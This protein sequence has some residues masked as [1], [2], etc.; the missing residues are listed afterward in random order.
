MDNE[1]SKLVA[2]IVVW[3]REL[4]I[5]ETKHFAAYNAYNKYLKEHN[6]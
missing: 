4:A 1:E 3:E 5:A 6:R 2:S